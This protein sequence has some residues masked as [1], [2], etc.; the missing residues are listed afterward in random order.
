MTITTQALPQH[1]RQNQRTL[2]SALATGAAGAAVRARIEY[3]GSGD[4]GS[5]SDV[6]IT[7]DDGL[8]FDD[9][10]AV[11]VLVRES[12]FVNGSWQAGTAGRLM[13]LRQA[14]EDFAEEVLEEL[15]GGWENNEGAEGQV[16]FELDRDGVASVSVEHNE[17]F[18]ESNYMET[19]L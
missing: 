13:T 9:Q 6:T 17:F 8:S 2:I 1:L 5:V 4:S 7:R 15:H 19:R 3:A 16:V 11:E 12:H 14:L 18:T 10:A